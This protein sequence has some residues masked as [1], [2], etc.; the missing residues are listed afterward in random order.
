MKGV[1]T[2]YLK[3]SVRDA[4]R[5]ACCYNNALVRVFNNA[6]RI[7]NCANGIVDKSMT[8]G[9]TNLSGKKRLD[10]WGQIHLVYRPVLQ[11]L[12]TI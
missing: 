3:D 12:I 5:Y 4:K 1:V 9:I 11:Q 10:I 2:E 8:M 6:R 7:L